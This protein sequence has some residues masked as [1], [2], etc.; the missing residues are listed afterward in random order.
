MT[1]EE[2]AKEFADRLNMMKNDCDLTFREI[3]RSTG[4]PHSSICMWTFG[5]KLPNAYSLARLAEYL[6]V[7]ADWLLG[8]SDE[9]GRET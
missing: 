8:L 9:M 1:R 3:S 4:I 7:S 5:E 2:M 6:G